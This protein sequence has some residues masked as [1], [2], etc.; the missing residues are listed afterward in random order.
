VHVVK[1]IPAGLPDYGLPQGFSASH[2]MRLLPGAGALALVAF[3]ESV[4][5]A[6]SYATQFNLRIDSD[7]ELIALGLCNV[8]SGFSGAFA[9][10]GSM[11]RTAAS[12]GAGAATQ[13]TS[14]VTAIAVLVTAAFLTPLFDFLPEAALAAIVIHAVW[15]LVNYHRVSQYWSITRLDFATALLAAVGVLTLGI[16]Q[17]IIIAVLLGLLGLLWGAKSRSAYVLGKVPGQELYRALRNHPD[18]ETYPGLVVVRYDSALFFA[19][20]PDFADEI[21]AGVEALE[22]TPEVILVDAESINDIDATAVMTL[23]ELARELHRSGVELRFASTKTRV[24]EIMLRAGIEEA[25]EREHF[26][27]S[28][29]AGVD[30]FLDER[31]LDSRPPRD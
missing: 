19:N 6:R 11:S 16:L 7:Q 27:P 30:A 22:P 18:G 8:G 5:I 20:A 31:K 9:V 23:S 25:I 15:H 26:Y 3:A 2:L 12:V 4:A 29:Q 17:G 14:I 21:R 28:I 10:D 24:F 13:M 1:D